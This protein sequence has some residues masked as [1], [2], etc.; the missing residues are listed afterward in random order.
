METL[1]EESLTLARIGTMIVGRDLDHDALVKK[2]QEAIHFIEMTEALTYDEATAK[3][4]RTFLEE[5]GIWQPLPQ[6][7]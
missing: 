5:K 3:R 4:I 1:L 2:Y 6:K 7:S